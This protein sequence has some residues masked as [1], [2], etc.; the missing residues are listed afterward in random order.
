MPMLDLIQEGNTGLIRA[1]E[2]FDYT[3][4]YKFS[5][6][7]TWWIRQAVTRGIA[8]QGRVVRLPVHV[9]EEINQLNTSRRN[10]EQMQG[11]APEPEDIAADMECSVE[12]VL[13]LM[14]WGREHISLDAPI[15]EDEDTSLWEVFAEENTHS[16]DDMLINQESREM[17][18]ELVGQLS[19]RKADIIR[20]H[21]GLV[22]GRQHR[23]ADIGLR[24]GISAERVRQLEYAALQ[25]LKLIAAGKEPQRSPERPQLPA[26]VKEF[27]PTRTKF[28]AIP[29]KHR[30]LVQSRL[31]SPDFD[32]S[33][34]GLS[35]QESVV[36]HHYVTHGT[37]AAVE[38]LGFKPSQ[39]KAL[40]SNALAKLVAQPAV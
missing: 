22:D 31:T 2:K 21:F 36:V 32:S 33:K 40:V 9:V 35:E 10:L 14:N 29:E 28:S 34:F 30:E 23:L 38:R 15:G 20:C 7:A 13:D 19:D 17:L 26:V 39:I 8:N 11:R 3:K 24:H 18:E 5:T 25:D 6:Y 4:G 16:T 1:V 37:I 27:V 12:H